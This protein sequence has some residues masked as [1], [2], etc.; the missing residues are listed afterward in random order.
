VFSILFGH[1][2]EKK[3]EKKL[4]EETELTPTVIL[5]DRQ[6]VYSVVPST[7]VD[8]SFVAVPPPMRKL[9]EGIISLSDLQISNIIGRG[10]FGEVYAASWNG[11]T[12][13]AKTL[14]EDMDQI[15][16]EINIIKKLKHPNI[17]H[18]YGVTDSSD[19]LKYIITE[20]C[21]AGDLRTLL[22]DNQ[23]ILLEQLIH[24]SLHIASGMAYLHS[25]QI[26]HRDLSAR[27]ILVVRQGSEGNYFAKVSDFG[28]SRNISNY[29]EAKANSKFPIRWAAPEVLKFQKC[30]SA[31]D[32]WSYGVTL[33]EM[34]ERGA[35]PYLEKDHVEVIKS[36]IEGHRLSRPVNAP[37]LLWDIINSCFADVKQRPTFKDISKKLQPYCEKKAETTYGDKYLSSYENN[38]PQK[39]Y[40]AE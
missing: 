16:I 30:S 31:S 22:I 8:G 6:T 2:E 12:V 1:E 33:W 15:K 3:Q 39:N 18:F 36:V 5:A 27:N 13:A 28:M 35:V 10:E 7:P 9:E 21:D 29:Y 23:D 34:L 14:K 26:I 4:V 25:N 40:F 11:I 20:Y 32:V 37:D 17:V 24:M 38:Q 19:G